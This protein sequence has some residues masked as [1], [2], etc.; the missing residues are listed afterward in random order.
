MSE[1]FLKVLMLILRDDWDGLL[2]YL[3]W[4]EIQVNHI[5]TSFDDYEWAGDYET[6]A[7]HTFPNRNNLIKVVIKKAL[8]SVV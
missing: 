3:T 2:K 5:E 8:D 7:R 1:E 6:D 4:Q